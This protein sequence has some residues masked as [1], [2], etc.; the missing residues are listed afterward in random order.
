MYL[1]VDLHPPETIRVNR[2]ATVGILGSLLQAKIRSNPFFVQCGI[3]IES[4]I[5][6][7]RLDFNPAH[8][9]IINPWS[10]IALLEVLLMQIAKENNFLRSCNI[11]ISFKRNDV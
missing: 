3:R 2:A 5:D 8:N 9:L 4:E 7:L 11:A 1:L 10:L 6:R